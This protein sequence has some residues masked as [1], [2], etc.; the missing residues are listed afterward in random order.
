MVVWPAGHS[1]RVHINRFGTGLTLQNIE[2]MMSIIL[3]ISKN[4]IWPLEC[5]ILASEHNV[6]SCLQYSESILNTPSHLCMDG[7][8]GTYTVSPHINSYPRP[9]S[10]LAGEWIRLAFALPNNIKK[11]L[12]LTCDLGK[13]ANERNDAIDLLSGGVTTWPDVRHQLFHNRWIKIFR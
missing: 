1:R 8:Q 10:D 4:W 13:L 5:V 9:L 7:V 3:V 6:S 2:K 12:S 11:G